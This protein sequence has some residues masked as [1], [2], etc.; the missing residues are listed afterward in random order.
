MTHPTPLIRS[1]VNPEV[2]RAAEYFTDGEITD[3]V[4]RDVAA[5][6]RLELYVVRK[7]VVE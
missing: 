7:E 3:Q 2:Y 5:M 6:E 4:L 1:L